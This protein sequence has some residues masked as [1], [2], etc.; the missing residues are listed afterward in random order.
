MEEYSMT[1]AETARLI[2]WLEVKG[3]TAEEAIECIKYI[4][5]AQ[6]PKQ[7]K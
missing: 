6:E 1:A 7:G 4:A 2:E 3:H 5:N